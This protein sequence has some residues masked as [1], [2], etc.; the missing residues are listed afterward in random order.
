VS[1]PVDAL[2]T[3]PEGF[4]RMDARGRLEAELNA[5]RLQTAFLPV[6]VYDAA[7]CVN[8]LAV[9]EGYARCTSQPQLASEVTQLQVLL[10]KHINFGPLTRQQ[11]EANRRLLELPPL[12]Q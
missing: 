2:P 5:S 8:G 10:R 12:P 9:L 11:F 4:E 6:T 7:Q 3:P 1:I